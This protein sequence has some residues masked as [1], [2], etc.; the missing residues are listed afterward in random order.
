MFTS[1]APLLAT[2]VLVGCNRRADPPAPADHFRGFLRLGPEEIS[3][4]PCG[5]SREH[6]WWWEL[7]GR[8]LTRKQ[9]D[10]WQLAEPILNSQPRCDINTMPC[11]LQEAYVE[12]NG[13]VSQPGHFG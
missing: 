2:A 8:P 9:A 11:K 10:G 6:R 12:L 1:L 5:T 13:V 7:E 4:Q 3:F